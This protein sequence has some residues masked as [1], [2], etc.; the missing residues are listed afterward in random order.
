MNE[1][2]P[3][4]RLA[5]RIREFVIARDW[6]QFQSPKNLSMALIVEAAELVEH[7]QWLTQEQSMHLPVETAR[8]VET[9]LADIF[10]YL[11]RM[12]DQ[13]DV[14][15]IEAADRKIEINA[16]KYPVERF[17]GSPRKYNREEPAE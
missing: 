7:F 4:D 16:G 15:L 3:L 1:S 11:L 14:D 13:L 10:I 2:E 6:D 8:E 12:A 5:M 17:R 9:E